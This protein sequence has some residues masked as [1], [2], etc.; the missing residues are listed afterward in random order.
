REEVKQLRW[1][2]NFTQLLR[3]PK[4]PEP[5]AGF[6]PPWRRTAAQGDEAQM[7]APKAESGDGQPA[8]GAPDGG[9][10]AEQD[11]ILVDG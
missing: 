8:E 5:P 11:A 10:D 9:P 4:R 7:A 6:V 1:G 3:K 2:L